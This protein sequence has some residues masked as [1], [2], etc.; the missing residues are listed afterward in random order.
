[1]KNESIWKRL[2]GRRTLVQ[3]VSALTLNSY[4]T[5]YITKGI[6]CPAMNCYAC[7]AA[8]SACPIGTIQ[9]FIVRKKFPLYALG[10]IGLVGALI[11]RASCGWF[12]P[13]GWFQELVY[14]LPIP[15]R[16]LPN[17]F[18]WTR[19]VI[20]A[21]LVVA[22]PYITRDPWFCKLCPVGALE[23]SIPMALLSTDIRDMVG[24][25]YWIKL[26]ILGTLLA[27]MS[28]TRRPFCRWI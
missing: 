24:A 11:G 14:K 19:Y 25:L 10:V 7:P 28:V 13:F 18:N 17:R 9:H 26:G 4:F 23:A 21:V 2:A 20:L 27:W 1:M 22:I 5:R 8:A 3:L 12:C 16:R 6:P 15:K